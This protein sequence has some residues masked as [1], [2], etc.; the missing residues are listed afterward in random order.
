MSLIKKIIKGEDVSNYDCKTRLEHLLKKKHCGESCDDVEA[1][2]DIE[3]L[4]KCMGAGGGVTEIETLDETL[5]VNANVGKIY[6]CDGK[7]Y[8]VKLIR[9]LL[10]ANAKFKTDVMNDTEAFSQYLTG[11][12]NN[13]KELFTTQ[14]TWCPNTYCLY[15]NLSSGYN[16][17]TI[18]LD[19]DGKA[20]EFGKCYDDGY[21]NYWTI[22]GGCDASEAPTDNDSI[23]GG[24]TISEAERVAC[25]TNQTIISFLEGFCDIKG[26]TSEIVFEKCNKRLVSLAGATV[27]FKREVL[28]DIPTFT[29]LVTDLYKNF[30]DE[31][32]CWGFYLGGI[33]IGYT[34]DPYEHLE[35]FGLIGYGDENAT[36][37]TPSEGIVNEN[38]LLTKYDINQ[39]AEVR[40]VANNEFIKFILACCDVVGGIYE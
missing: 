20:I 34:Y 31:I 27:K 22:D 6:Q 35:S 39:E 23:V 11:F 32:S 4:V 8:V 1:V 25:L 16:G 24:G 5:L 38:L 2:T 18:T 28:N 29:T 17:I 19:S 15:V 30:G 21:Y 13:N 7:F 12:Y 40:T 33:R 10:D 37:W 14:W 36:L 9:N 26:I 3:K